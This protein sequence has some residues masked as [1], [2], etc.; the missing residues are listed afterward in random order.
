VPSQNICSKGIQIQNISSFSQMENIGKHEYINYKIIEGD[1]TLK[2]YNT[3]Y[4]KGLF[5]P[6]KDKKI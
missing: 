5:G 2:K 4:Y 1:T 3:S 6:P